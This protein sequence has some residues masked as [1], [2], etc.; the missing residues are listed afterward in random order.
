LAGVRKIIYDITEPNA[1]AVDI[2]CGT[3]E[4]VFFLAPRL[5]KVIGLDINENV[6]KYS[7]KK[8]RGLEIDNVKFIE[9]DVNDADFLNKYQF[10]YAILSMVLH[11]FSTAEA[12]QVLDSAKKVARYI[13]LVDF[14][15]PLPAT[16]AGQGALLI[17]KIAGGEHYNNFKA[18]QKNNGLNY[19]LKNHQLSII[20][21]KLGG[22]N[23]IRIVK[24][25]SKSIQEK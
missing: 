1:T 16:I 25:F 9:K 8:M 22:L 21:D 23:V 15:I 17:E 4:L 5:T 18:Y 6:L 14:S 13:I 3:G 12:N 24:T 20:E 7:R 11:Q 19:F 2:G 10:D